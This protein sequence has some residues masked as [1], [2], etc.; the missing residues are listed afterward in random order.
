ML[1]PQKFC[2][3]KKKIVCVVNFLKSISLPL[4]SQLSFKAGITPCLERHLNFN[5]FGMA[6][7]IEHHFMYIFFSTP[8]LIHILKSISLPSLSYKS[9]MYHKP[10][11][12]NSATNTVLPSTVTLSLFHTM[13]S[14][15]TWSIETLQIT[16]TTT[17]LVSIYIA[18][19]M[20]QYHL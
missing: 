20:K 5:S 17:K 10:A 9:E 4:K 19:N 18:P 7:T 2:L 11:I 13:V 12:K 14:Q 1:E 16:T 6:E 15:R 8:L 3:S